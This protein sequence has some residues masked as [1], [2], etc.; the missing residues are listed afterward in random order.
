[1]LIDFTAA[2]ADGKPVVDLTPADVAIRIGGKVRTISSLE[3]KT[4]QPAAAP[5]AAPAAK[6]AAEAG[7]ITPP[8]STN[9]AKAASQALGRSVLIVVDTESLVASADTAVKGAVEDLLKGLTS[10][11]RV[12]LSTVPKDTAQVG[13]GTG[14]ARVRT[15][16]ADLKGQRPAT[17]TSANAACRTS[18]SLVALN[19]LIQPLAGG[20][21]P[22]SVVFIAASLV[23]PMT[24]PLVGDSGTCQVVQS[25]Y[26]AIADSAAVARVN[27]YIVQGDPGTMGRD[28]GLENLAGVT[29]AGQVMRVV[30]EGF[31]PRVLAEASTY[32]VATLAPDPSDRPGQAQRLDVKAVREGVTMHARASAAVSRA[33]AAPAAAKS[34]SATP[35]EMIATM[36]PFTDLQLRAMAYVSRGQGEKMN[37]L[38]FAE[39]V[40]PTVKIAAM[41]IGYFDQ[42]NKGA[43]TDAP[44]VATYP[45]AMGP[46]PLD[47][48]R[49]RVRVAATDTS[50]KSGAVDVTVNAAL[51]PAGPLKL[52]SLLLGAPTEK[53]MSPRVQFSSEEKI[54]A[55]LEMF[56]QITG[57]ISVKFEL[58]K[59]DSGPAITTLQA[60]GGGPTSEPDKFQINGEMPIAK[61]EPGD[62]VLRAVVQMEGQPEGKV[63]RTFRKIAK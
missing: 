55:Y 17:V 37:M 9:E 39:P 31:A 44:Q 13:F 43:S 27:V 34:G 4:V 42:A 38:V 62:Y 58:A 33:A 3:L 28:T 26:Q 48:G 30:A 22:T 12:A 46:L 57:G 25:H 19:S 36:A 18:Q 20:E 52:G 50:G 54:I 53:G 45:I 6:P 59:S 21:T 41:R 60:T 35:K 51:T 11:D 49:Y 47:A 10:A 61:L 56:G 15:A 8:F 29:G 7:D 5:A 24:S 16:V 14:L 32:W 23:T 63:L 2:T 1:M 40:D